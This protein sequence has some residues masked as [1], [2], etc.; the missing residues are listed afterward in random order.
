MTFADTLPKP[1]TCADEPK[2]PAVP[3]HAECGRDADPVRARMQV[4]FR[5]T[6]REGLVNP[7]L[8]L[9]PPYR[10]GEAP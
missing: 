6:I 4:L 3:A 1:Q 10:L 9:V 5:H 8:H 2:E 7:L